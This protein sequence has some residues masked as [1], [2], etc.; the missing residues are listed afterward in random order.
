MAKKLR[1]TLQGLSIAAGVPYSTTY[2]W[3]S[4]KGN[5]KIKNY[6]AICEYYGKQK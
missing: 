5:F 2:R 6:N 1:L 3:E 4:N